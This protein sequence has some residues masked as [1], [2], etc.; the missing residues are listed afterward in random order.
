MMI[1]TGETQ[2]PFLALNQKILLDKKISYAVYLLILE[3]FYALCKFR[4]I[5]KL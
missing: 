5:L 3:K 2:I 1:P 4:K